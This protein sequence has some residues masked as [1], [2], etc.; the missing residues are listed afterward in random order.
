M[1]FRFKLKVS[2]PPAFCQGSRLSNLLTSDGVNM[3]HQ[4]PMQRF[5]QRQHPVWFPTVTLDFQMSQRPQTCLRGWLP[6]G[7]STISVF[8]RMLWWE[9]LGLVYSVIMIVLS[10]PE[11]NSICL[12]SNVSSRTVQLRK[13][14]VGPIRPI[15]FQ[16]LEIQPVYWTNLDVF[17]GAKSWLLMFTWKVHITKQTTKFR[18][19]SWV[20]TSE[21]VCFSDHS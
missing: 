21:A 18:T 8:A 3:M 20:I 4:T 19:W 5:A 6:F 12:V 15:L 16:T 7:C 17:R 1:G 11:S 13:F 2:V 14:M 10:A 9:L